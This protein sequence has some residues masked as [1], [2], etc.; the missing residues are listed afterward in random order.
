MDKCDTSPLHL[1]CGLDFFIILILNKQNKKLY[2]IGVVGVRR[3]IIK[4]KG[5]EKNS[6]LWGLEKVANN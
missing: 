1:V 5:K 2:Y 4:L 3:I 6:F